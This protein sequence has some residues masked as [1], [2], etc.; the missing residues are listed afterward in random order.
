[1]QADL[2][3]VMRETAVWL[4]AV[5]VQ[6]VAAIENVGTNRYGSYQWRTLRKTTWCVRCDCDLPAG[7]E[8]LAYDWE[9]R[10]CIPCGVEEFDFVYW[11]TPE[12]L[13]RRAAVDAERGR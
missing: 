1:M 8:A 10:W 12:H 2:R 4:D 3:L 5:G 6:R 7:I 9:T 11:D 13:A